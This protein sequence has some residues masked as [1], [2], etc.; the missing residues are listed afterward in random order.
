MKKM[1]SEVKLKAMMVVVGLLNEMLGMMKNALANAVPGCAYVITQ[2]NNLDV[3]YIYLARGCCKYI[4]LY[5][6][7]LAPSQSICLLYIDTRYKSFCTGI[8]SSWRDNINS[9]CEPA[10]RVRSC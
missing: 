6:W 3:Q 10:M 7:Q 9:I 5:G 2:C 4:P 8:K 1:S